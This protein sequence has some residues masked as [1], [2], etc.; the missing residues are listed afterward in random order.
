MPFPVSEL[1][2]EWAT[3]VT[4]LPAGTPTGTVLTVPPTPQTAT[5]FTASPGATAI[6][7][8]FSRLGGNQPLTPGGAGSTIG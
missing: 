5:Q 4:V 1:D 8:C 6:K 3:M 7:D 2:A